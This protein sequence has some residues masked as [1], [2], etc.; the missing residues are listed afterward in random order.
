MYNF[1]SALL[2]KWKSILTFG[3]LCKTGYSS[4]LGFDSKYQTGVFFP[5]K[6][7]LVSAFN[8]CAWVANKK[9]ILFIENIV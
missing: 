4:S 1:N 8:S 6:N 7:G 2:Y 9:L 5:A 3:I